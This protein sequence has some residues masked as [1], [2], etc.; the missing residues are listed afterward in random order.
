MS[1]KK[2]LNGLGPST[3]KD[4]SLRDLIA[5]LVPVNSGTR[6]EKPFLDSL[7]ESTLIP[8]LGT[9]PLTTFQALRILYLSCL[10]S[11]ERNP[12]L[13]SLSQYERDWRPEILL[14]KAQSGDSRASIAPLWATGA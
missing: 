6:R 8:Q 7:W 9:S 1:F 13:A 12:P 3:K 14:V 11:L 2:L 4:P 10:L 5:T